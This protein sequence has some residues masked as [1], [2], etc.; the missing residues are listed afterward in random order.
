MDWV[1]IVLA[2]VAGALLLWAVFDPPGQWRVLNGWATRDPA[3]AEPGNAIHGVRRVIAGLGLVGM[4]VVS[5]FALAGYLADRPQPAQERAALEKMWGAPTPGLLDRVII[6]TSA[7]PAGL[8]EA[9]IVA[10]Q[11]IV[12]GDAPRYL[13]TAPRWSYLGDPAPAGIV[14]GQAPDGETGYGGASVLLSVRGPLLCIPRSI[15][16]IESEDEVRVSVWFGLPDSPATDA[17]TECLDDP[18]ASERVLIPL[19]L[20]SEI[21]EREL[22]TAEG[23]PVRIIETPTPET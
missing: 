19:R 7:P 11:A 10:A 5:G 21:G 12:P 15:V 20:G 3:A 9:E 4:V 6:G 14:G 23:T 22:L 1:F 2:V 17:V 18:I 8:V 13:L 16:V